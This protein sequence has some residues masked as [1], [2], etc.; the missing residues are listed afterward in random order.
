MG[1]EHS[2]MA[3]VPVFECTTSSPFTLQVLGDMAAL[4]KQQA[5][6]GMDEDTTYWVSEAGALADAVFLVS[7]YQDALGQPMGSNGYEL[8][9]LMDLNKKGR[10]H[11]PC[12]EYGLL[13]CHLDDLPGMHVVRKKGIPSGAVRHHKAICGFLPSLCTS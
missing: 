7:L 1:T 2:M 8:E 4:K 13:Q 3:G 5:Q 6:G 12:A 11:D 9:V 10:D